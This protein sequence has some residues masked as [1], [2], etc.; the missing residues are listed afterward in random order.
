MPQTSAWSMPML[1]RAWSWRSE[2]LGFI[3]L[4][5]GSFPGLA[6]ADALQEGGVWMG[7]CSSVRPFETLIRNKH[8][9][10][11]LGE[12]VDIQS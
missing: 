7:R 3:K 6:S 1:Q 2:E 10:E 9:F 5:W 12:R 8:G 4:W 11:C